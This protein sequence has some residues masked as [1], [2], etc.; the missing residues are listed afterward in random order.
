[1]G[2]DRQSG[3]VRQKKLQH[4]G[5]NPDTAQKS[6]PYGAWAELLSYLCRITTAGSCRI[7]TASVDCV[8]N[9]LDSLNSLGLSLSLLCVVTASGSSYHK[10]HNCN[11]HKYLLHNNYKLKNYSYSQLVFQVAKVHSFLKITIKI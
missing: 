10:S 11:R 4:L 8:N 6:P 7:A 2:K 3:G 9:F 5:F 1:M